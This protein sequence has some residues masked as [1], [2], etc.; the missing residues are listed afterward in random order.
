MGRFEKLRPVP[1]YNGNVRKGGAHRNSKRGNTF[2]KILKLDA[3]STSAS[4]AS[5]CLYRV[6]VLPVCSGK[7]TN[8]VDGLSQP[9][10][11]DAPLFTH[12]STLSVP[13]T[14]SVYKISFFPEALGEAR[15]QSG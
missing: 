4:H 13:R 1:Q 2:V 5:Q 7:N 11:S 8:S 6:F 3:E 12:F 9:W 15:P 14:G 10:W